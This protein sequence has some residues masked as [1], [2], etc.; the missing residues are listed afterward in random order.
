ML[1]RTIATILLL[2]FASNGLAQ[3]DKKTDPAS[4]DSHHYFHAKETAHAAA[5]GYTGKIGPANWANLS[6]E[7]SLAKTGKRQSPIDIKSSQVG[8]L[9]KIKFQYKPAPVR[10]VYNGHT[11]EEEEEEGSTIS[12]RNMTYGL[13]Q[14]HFHSPSEHTVDG[15]YF[16]MEMHLVHKA[17]NGQVAVVA[18][19]I[20]QV[21]T[22]NKSFALLLDTLPTKANPRT[23]SNRGIDATSLLPT[24]HGYF[25]Y[26]GSFTTPPCTEG[27]KWFV[28]QE[29]IGLSK[30]QIDAFRKTIDGN[31]R[32]IQPRHDRV[33]YRS[34]R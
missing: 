13:K 8:P 24:K 18:V 30:K 32:P 11:M 4:D 15:K 31:N 34:A 19:L 14:F 10:M 21:D 5:W 28:L 26:E 3:Q 12:V 33:I 2:A 27:V 29:P 22:P 9:P 1:N 16:S 7:Y 20:K 6:P 17:E 23:A 25:A